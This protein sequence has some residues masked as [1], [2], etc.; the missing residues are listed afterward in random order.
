MKNYRHGDPKG[1]WI[2]EAL[3]ILEISSEAYLV[4][5]IHATW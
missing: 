5:D 4:A 1:I 3:V 2:P